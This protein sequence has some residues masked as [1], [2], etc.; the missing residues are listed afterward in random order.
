MIA[1]SGSTSIDNES[2]QIGFA[3]L[4]LPD[5]S[6]RI[7][8]KLTFIEKVFGLGGGVFFQLGPNLHISQNWNENVFFLIT[9]FLHI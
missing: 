5:G 9:F 7:K 2:A 6:M 8:K 3:I 1:H 4:N